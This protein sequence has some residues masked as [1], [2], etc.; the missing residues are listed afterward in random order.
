MIFTTVE[1][2]RLKARHD[3]DIDALVKESGRWFKVSVRL[4]TEARAMLDDLVAAQL[5]ITRLIAERDNWFEEAASE[6]AIN[7]HYKQHLP[8]RKETP[9][10]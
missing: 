9:T 6:H 10:T 2:A 7:E 1:L 4:H 8:K 3:P 5:E